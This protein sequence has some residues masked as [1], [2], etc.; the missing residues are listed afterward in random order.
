MW[1]EIGHGIPPSKT[2]VPYST[3][4][5]KKNGRRRQYEWIITLQLFNGRIHNN[6]YVSV[7]TGVL[8]SSIHIKFFSQNQSLL[9]NLKSNNNK[10][11]ERIKLNNADNNSYGND[12]TT[13]QAE[14]KDG[15]YE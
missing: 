8:S 5:E 7:S 10:K 14:D 1:E 6:K 11:V 15:Y 3:N 13:T 2:E 4:K 9:S 12:T